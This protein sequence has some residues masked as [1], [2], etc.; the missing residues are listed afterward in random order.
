MKERPGEGERGRGGE[1][2]SESE[3]ERERERERR[4]ITRDPGS[5]GPIRK[6]I[7]KPRKA[8]CACLAH[9]KLKKY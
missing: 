8:S 2:K 1:R 6:S 9:S 3:R 5:P 7:P 4:E